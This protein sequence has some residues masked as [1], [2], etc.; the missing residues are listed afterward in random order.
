MVTETTIDN[1]YKRA[2]NELEH[3]AVAKLCRDRDNYRDATTRKIKPSTGYVSS[4]ERE[5]YQKAKFRNE[6]TIKT[7]KRFLD[8]VGQN[9]SNP[10]IYLYIINGPTGGADYYH[11]VPE[12]FMPFSGSEWKR[13]M[14]I[15]QFEA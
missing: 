8:Q 2:S 13:K 12:N 5:M 14:I 7:L 3:N 9:K 15:K 11:G 4:S 6:N 10:A 1:L